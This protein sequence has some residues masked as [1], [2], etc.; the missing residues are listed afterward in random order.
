MGAYLDAYVQLEDGKQFGPY[1]VFVSLDADWQMRGT[2]NWR[3]RR[4]SGPPARVRNVIFTSPH[5]GVGVYP[6][7]DEE[8]RGGDSVAFTFELDPRKRIDGWLDDPQKIDALCRS[9]LKKEK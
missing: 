8:V 2:F 7:T 6:G 9:N 1:S 4:F 5:M 3:R